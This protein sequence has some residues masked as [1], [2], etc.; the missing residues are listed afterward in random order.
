MWFFI[1]ELCLKDVTFFRLGLHKSMSGGW[2]KD[3][4]PCQSEKTALDQLLQF[5]A[6]SLQD[7]VRRSDRNR[8]GGIILT[9]LLA[10]D[11]I[12]YLIAAIKRHGLL[13]KFDDLVAGLC[14]LETVFKRRKIC[15]RVFS[16]PYLDKYLT[17]L[18][19]DLEHGN[20]ETERSEVLTRVGF[21]ALHHVM[22]STI[23]LSFCK[24][25]NLGFSLIFFS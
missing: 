11:S 18:H 8:I 22:V 10:E 15:R 12:I 19:I 6:T 23:S 20:L 5:M 14:H 25:F 2:L 4:L 21:I 16:L 13:K 7:E 3:S 17:G 9:T 1:T 24:E